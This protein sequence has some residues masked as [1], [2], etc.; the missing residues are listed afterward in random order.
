MLSATCEPMVELNLKRKLLFNEHK[1]FLSKSAGTAPVP[2]NNSS[3]VVLLIWYAVININRYTGQTR[4]RT[5]LLSCLYSLTQSELY[6]SLLFFKTQRCT[7]AIL[8]RGYPRL[9]NK[10]WGV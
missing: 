10:A 2:Y 5:K 9:L 7:G 6:S 8:Y 3:F 4:R 1:C